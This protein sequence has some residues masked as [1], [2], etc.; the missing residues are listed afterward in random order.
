[1]QSLKIV[2]QDIGVGLPS[3]KLASVSLSLSSSEV[4]DHAIG[5][6][7]LKCWQ[8][9]GERDTLSLKCMKRSQRKWI[10]IISPYKTACLF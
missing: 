9:R 5:L 1:M 3:A 8:E 6:G 2:S 7:P 4:R 10:A